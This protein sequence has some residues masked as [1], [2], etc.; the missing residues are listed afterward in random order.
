[1]KLLSKCI[2][3]RPRRS[4]FEAKNTNRRTGIH[5]VIGPTEAFPIP[6]LGQPHTEIPPISSHVFL[7]RQLLLPLSGHFQGPWAGD[8]ISQTS[9]GI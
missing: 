5:E 6:G 4:A 1:M 7:S 2:Y 9:T 3:S 8:L